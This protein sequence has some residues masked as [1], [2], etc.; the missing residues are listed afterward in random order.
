MDYSNSSLFPFFDSLSFIAIPVLILILIWVLVIKGIALWKSARN[1]DKWWF[2]ALL[3]INT[4]G[5]LELVYI[6]WFAKKKT[7]SA[8]T[9]STS[10]EE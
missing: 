1:G 4:L 2:I 7:P 3:L 10:T 8:P 5:I 6:I 9:L